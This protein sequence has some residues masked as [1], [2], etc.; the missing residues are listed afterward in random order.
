MEIKL[1]SVITCPVCGHQKEEEMPVDMC[2]YFY[3]CEQCK[4]IL[5]PLHGDCC[6]FCSYGTVKCP[7]QQLIKD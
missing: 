2:Q 1:K 3:S 4:S 6:V 7:S 5:K